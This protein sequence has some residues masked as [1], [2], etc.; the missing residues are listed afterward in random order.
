MYA[1]YFSKA[2][3]LGNHANYFRHAARDGY[4]SVGDLLFFIASFTGHL[5]V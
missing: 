1:P 5:Y 2:L 4:R 3:I